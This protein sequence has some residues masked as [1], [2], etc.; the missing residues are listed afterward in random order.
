MHCSVYVSRSLR[1]ILSSFTDLALEV[2]I[3]EFG[4]GLARKDCQKEDDHRVDGDVPEHDPSG[5]FETPY[6]EHIEV[7]HDQ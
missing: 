2:S 4:D 1:K 7:E 6:G 5:D 3:P